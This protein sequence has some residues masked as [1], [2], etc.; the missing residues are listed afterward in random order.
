[1]C[2]PCHTMT[3]KAILIAATCGIE[4]VNLF[5]ADRSRVGPVIG[6]EI[7]RCR[8][9]DVQH[10]HR[11]SAAAAGAEGLIATPA[12]LLLAASPASIQWPVSCNLCHPVTM[13]ETSSRGSGEAGVKR[14]C[15]AFRQLPGRQEERNLFLDAEITQNRLNIGMKCLVCITCSACWDFSGF[16]LFCV[17]VQEMKKTWTDW[18]GRLSSTCCQFYIRLHPSFA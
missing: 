6:R 12:C 16:S 18:M 15:A 13:C 3:L 2:L 1:M 7:S 17:R 5:G 14:D 9:S 11:A 8:C 10:R 4:N